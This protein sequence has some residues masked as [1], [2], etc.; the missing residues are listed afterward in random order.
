MFSYLQEE[1]DIVK[2]F[3]VSHGVHSQTFSNKHCFR[4]LGYRLW[5]KPL[6]IK[7]LKQPW[8]T[9][10]HRR[11]LLHCYCPSLKSSGA[12]HR[13]VPAHQLR[14]ATPRPQFPAAWGGGHSTLPTLPCAHST[15]CWEKPDPKKLSQKQ[16]G[17]AW[18]AGKTWDPRL[19]YLKGMPELTR[20][21]LILFSVD[22]FPSPNHHEPV[23][24]QAQGQD[25]KTSSGCNTDFKVHM[26]FI[27]KCSLHHL[28]ELFSP[29]RK[30][31]RLKKTPDYTVCHAH[32]A[33]NWITSY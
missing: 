22:L 1:G 3:I 12:F 17:A 27:T 21:T 5:P 32:N 15:S 20:L 28:M 10:H 30:V 33:H 31:K 26:H 4:V 24:I 7:G 2:C 29:F 9:E 19:A 14:S 16:E 6:P 25:D 23:Q 8:N 13:W 11:Q 18:E